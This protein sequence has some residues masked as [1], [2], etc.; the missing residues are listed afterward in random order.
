MT[1]YEARQKLGLS[2][3]EMVRLLNVPRSTWNC[4]EGI[5]GTTRKP[6]AAA[7]SLMALWVRL[8]DEEPA[9]YARLRKI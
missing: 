4:W 2:I 1:P 7:V 8:H 6:D 3:A 5:G 9:A